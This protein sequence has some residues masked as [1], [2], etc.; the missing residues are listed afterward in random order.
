MKRALGWL[1]GI[2]ILLG[3]AAVPT[4]GY[5]LFHFLGGNYDPVDV[6][7]AR[8]GTRAAVEVVPWRVTPKNRLRM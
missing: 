1:E 4:A 5:F 7:L 3:V 8:E 6:V 2:A